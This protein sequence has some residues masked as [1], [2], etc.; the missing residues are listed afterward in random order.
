MVPTSI[1]IKPETGICLRAITGGLILAVCLPATAIAATWEQALSLPVSVEY[2]SNPRLSETDRQSVRRTLLTP[3][4]SLTATDGT[5]QWFARLR[6]RIERSSNT[7]ISAD[8]EDPSIDLG[9]NHAHETGQF[10]LTAHFDKKSTRLSELEDTGQLTNDNTRRSRT[11]SANWSNALSERYTLN[12]NASLNKVSFDGAGSGLNDYQDKS[13][14]AQLGYSLDAQ[15]DTFARI[16]LSRFEPVSGSS[17][18]IRSLDIGA[19]WA[20]SERINITG[21]AG[22]NDSSGA[23]TESG[24]QAR[25]DMS[26]LTERSHSNLGLSRTRSPSGAGVVNESNQLQAGWRY[27]LSERDNVGVNFNWRE[28]LSTNTGK[29]LRLGAN[30]TRQLSPSWDF[31]VSAQRLKRDDDVSNAFSN[32]L[33]ATLVYK[34][35]DF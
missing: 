22:V 31:R 27:A 24:W 4:Y 29:T 28:N 8:R 20:L 15:T 10:G 33:T 12:L 14:S 32:T 1:R 25:F 6:L 26:Y 9:W 17:T 11:L 16:S 3:D 23:T 2:E 18:K 35:T 13:I 5:D 19:T 30:Y 21:S 7:A 34:L